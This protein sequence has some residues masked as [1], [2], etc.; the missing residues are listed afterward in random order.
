M[1]DDSTLGRNATLKLTLKCL[2]SDDES[3][4]DAVALFF[5]FCV[6]RT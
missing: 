6:S 4:G 3:G 2:K 5:I 1:M